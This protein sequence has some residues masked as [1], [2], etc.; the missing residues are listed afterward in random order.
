[1]DRDYSIRSISKSTSRNRG[2]NGGA[3]NN[4]VNPTDMEGYGKSRSR[5]S[6][7][8]RKRVIRRAIMLVVATVV[9]VLFLISTLFGSVSLTITPRSEAVAIDGVFNAVLAPLNNGDLRYEILQ[10]ISFEASEKIAAPRKERNITK[11]TGTLTVF[12]ANE[13]G[14]TLDLINR[15][16]FVFDGKTYRLT[17]PQKVPGGSTINGSFVPGTLEIEVVADEAG[18]SYNILNTGTRFTIPGL[19]KYEDYADSYAVSKTEI[20]GGF[21]GERYIADEDDVL[22]A[23]GRLMGEIKIQLLDELNKRITARLP[24]KLFIPEESI[25]I[26]YKSKPQGQGD[27]VVTVI[28][29]GSLKAVTFRESELARLIYEKTIKD[30]SVGRDDLIELERASLSIDIEDVEDLDISNVTEFSFRM[31]GDTVLRW[32]VDEFA[33]FSDL[34]GLSRD[35]ALSLITKNYP[36]IIEVND[37]TISPFWRRSITKNSN[38]F[39]LNIISTDS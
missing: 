26:E 23:E 15:S 2:S 1:M 8:R 11:S 28:Q 34:K 25:F 39:T 13:S 38:R 32:K 30:S 18:S 27:K 16:R 5:R 10:G 35:E 19:A 21:A 33:L 12:N 24:Q 36:Q 3:P 4:G 20:V 9:I 7:V 22:E 29:E 37:I 14:A 17:S 6:A 31:N